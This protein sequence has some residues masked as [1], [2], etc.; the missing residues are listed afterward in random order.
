MEAARVTDMRQRLDAVAA[1]VEA[2]LDLAR[3]GDVAVHALDTLQR[4]VDELHADQNELVQSIDKR[5]QGVEVRTR[6]RQRESRSA[7]RAELLRLRQRVY[8]PPDMFGSSRLRALDWRASERALAS[9]S[10]TDLAGPALSAV[11]QGH[12]AGA[13]WHVFAHGLAV[14]F[15]TLLTLIVVLARVTGDHVRDAWD[16]LMALFA[17]D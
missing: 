13:A 7:R 17:R 12:D 4:Q 2:A 15:G 3:G 1:R 8:A 5:I 6:L 9:A 11:R 16:H 10:A 14:F